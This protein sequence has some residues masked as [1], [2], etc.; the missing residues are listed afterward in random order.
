M[1]AAG[2]LKRPTRERGQR[3]RPHHLHRGGG[4]SSK[5]PGIDLTE[6]GARLV[7][8][9][10]RMAAGGRGSVRSKPFICRE[11]YG[12]TRMPADA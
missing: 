10:L 6:V 9:S 2:L 5:T 8:D 3:H 11:S 4:R 12:R 1:R 7:P